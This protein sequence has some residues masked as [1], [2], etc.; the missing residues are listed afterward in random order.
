MTLTVTENMFHVR[1]NVQRAE[2]RA[3]NPYLTLHCSEVILNSFH[4]LYFCLFHHTMAVIEALNN[5]VLMYSHC[6]LTMDDVIQWSSLSLCSPVESLDGWA[7]APT[8]I[9]STDWSQ[10]IYINPYVTMLTYCICNVHT[11]VMD[12]LNCWRLCLIIFLPNPNNNT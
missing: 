2:A 1:D 6:L 12:L 9:H 10:P 8:F 7:V 3:L 5:C 4:K 11:D